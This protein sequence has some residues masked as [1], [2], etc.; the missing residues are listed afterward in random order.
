MTCRVIVV[1][2]EDDIQ[3][4][5]PH[6]LEP[7]ECTVE[8][9]YTSGEELMERGLPD[10]V[11]V[12]VVDV[13]LGVGMT[14][15]DVARYLRRAYPEVAIVGFTGDRVAASEF[16]EDFDSMV[17]KPVHVGVLGHTIHSLSKHH[18]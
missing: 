12:A 9:Q 3:T 11:D 8:G 4:L 7:Y 2:D 16:A 15:I 6:A 10:D 18:R 5:L 14:G 1:D 17:V 13:N